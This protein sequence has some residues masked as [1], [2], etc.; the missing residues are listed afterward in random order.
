MRAEINWM[1]LD[2][3]GVNDGWLDYLLHEHYLGKKEIQRGF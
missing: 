1:M 2:L 3:H